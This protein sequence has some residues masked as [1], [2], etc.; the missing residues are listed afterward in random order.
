M[1]TET[2]P[3]EPAEAHVLHQDII[4]LLEATNLIEALHLEVVAIKVAH[5]LELEAQ[6]YQLHQEHQHIE[7]LVAAQE[8]AEQLEALAAEAINHTEAL[9]LEAL[10]VVEA[11]EAQVAHQEVLVA[12]GALDLHDHQAEAG[13]LHLEV[14]AEADNNRDKNQQNT[15]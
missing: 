14:A 15:F 8:A 10:E 12:Q 4:A 3:T 5:H 2:K 7:V 13:H 11:I 6:D 1:L 9:H